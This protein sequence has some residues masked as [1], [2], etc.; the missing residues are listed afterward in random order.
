MDDGPGPRPGGRRSAL[1]D[2]LGQDGHDLADLGAEA[3]SEIQDIHIALSGLPPKCKIVNLMVIAD[4]GNEWENDPRGRLFR[5][6]LRRQPGLEDRRPLPRAAQV[7]TGRPFSISLD[8]RR[9]P[10]GLVLGPGRPADPERPHARRLAQGPMGR[11]GRR[12][13]GRARAGRRAGRASRTSTCASRASRRRPRSSRLVLEAA[14]ACAWEF[15]TN[16]RGTPNAELDPRPRGSSRADPRSSA[17][18]RPDRPDPD[19]DGRLRQRPSRHRPPS[20]AG[21]CPTP[22]AAC[23]IAR[24]PAW[25]RTRI[26]GRLAGP[27]R[28]RSR[29]SATS[30]SSSTGPPAGRVR[31]SPP[32]LS[33]A[34][35]GSGYPTSVSPARAW[36]YELPLALQRPRDRDGPTSTSPPDRDESGDDDDAPPD[37]RRRLDGRRPVRRRARATPACASPG[38]ASADRRR[39]PGRRPQRAGQ[40]LRHRPAL[41]RARTP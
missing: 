26:D 3:P 40:P 15:G 17:R 41:A 8:V 21:R 35:R 11:P 31:S 22:T 24:C 7:E 5:A 39:P 28:G 38:I 20:V 27:G 1:G 32:M 10:S 14:A 2:W 12:D 18:P 6:V 9:R 36:P 19:A 29:A 16:P 37:L 4:G 13:H 33:D 34:I 25:P 30:T 23:P